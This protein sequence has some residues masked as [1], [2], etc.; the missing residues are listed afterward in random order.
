MS[1]TLG[2]G[3]SARHSLCIRSRMTAVQITSRLMHRP[4]TSLTASPLPVTNELLVRP[5][6]VVV[7]GGLAELVFRKVHGSIKEGIRDLFGH[8]RRV[9]GCFEFFYLHFPVHFLFVH[10]AIVSARQG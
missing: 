5:L 9:Q 8:G 3:P 6:N 7:G 1:S 10:G 4:D 2:L